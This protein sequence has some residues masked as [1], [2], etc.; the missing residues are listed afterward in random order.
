M[1]PRKQKEIEHYDNLA[2]TWQQKES[3]TDVH[4]LAH[5][6]FLSYRFCEN[7]LQKRC[8]GKKLLDYGCGNGLHSLFPAQHGAQVIGID[9]SEKSLEIAKRRTK[10][11]GL[12]NKIQFLK[13]D[14]EN[15]KF[16]D[17]SFDI[18]W[19]GGTFSSLDIKKALPEMARV[20]KPDGFVLGI[21]TLGHNPLF[22]LKRRFNLWRGTRT[23]WAVNHIIKMPDLKLA[24]KYFNKIQV[25]PFHLTLINPLDKVLLEIPGLRKYAFKIVFILSE[26]KKLS[27]PSKA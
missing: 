13:M 25:W 22:N 16:P 3:E 21:E 6:R 27:Q 7:Y 4:G 8:A 10:Q 1:E 24:Q 9:L 5:S 18:I 19:D 15:L 20:L 23:Q 17:D 2:Q 11:A 26:P 12:A 14:C